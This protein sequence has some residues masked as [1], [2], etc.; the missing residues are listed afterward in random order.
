MHKDIQ[1]LLEKNYLHTYRYSEISDPIHNIFFQNDKYLKISFDKKY[2][3]NIFDLL[4]IEYEIKNTGLHITRNNSNY[5]EV[6]ENSKIISI[7][8]NNNVLQELISPR[9]FYEVGLETEK[10]VQRNITLMSPILNNE[11]IQNEFK[12]VKK[13]LLIKLRDL[14]DIS[15]L[16]KIFNQNNE[17]ELLV[18]DLRD[19]QGGSF[20]NAIKFLEYFISKQNIILFLKD[21]NNNKYKVTSKQSEKIGFKKLSILCNNNTISSA[22]VIIKSLFTA[23]PN[24]VLIGEKT[25]GKDVVT[26]VFSLGKYFIKIPQY[27]YIFNNYLD[28]NPYVAPYFHY[29]N[30]RIRDILKG[31][32]LE[33]EEFD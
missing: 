15:F 22:E 25:G 13:N 31:V 5:K 14:S 4:G 8:N 29:K 24:S 28:E 20:I 26:N 27:K 21:R 23:Y 33:V 12:F 19:N 1:N 6:I 32:E 30:V 9:D 17:T 7:N 18:I 3:W 16:D 2:F 10:G 11:Y